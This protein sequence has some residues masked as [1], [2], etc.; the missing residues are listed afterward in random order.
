MSNKSDDR[1]V[2]MPASASDADLLRR[3]EPI[4]HFTK[5]EQFY[6]MDV[7]S[8]VRECSLWEH[9]PEGGEAVLVRQGELTLEELVKPRPAPFR[10]V[11]FLRFIETLSLTEAAQALA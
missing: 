3:F 9:T 2:A 5:G 8:Y 7:E 4:C 10:T 6:P 11:H 1:F